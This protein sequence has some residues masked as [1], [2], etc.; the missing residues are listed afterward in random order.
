[1]AT[2]V[3]PRPDVLQVPRR[4]HR[5]RALL[6]LG[7]AL[8]SV[9]LWGTRIRNLVAGADDFSAAFIG[10]HA[11]LYGVSLAIA[12]VLAVVGV[13]MWRESREDREGRASQGDRE[14]AE[15]PEARGAREAARP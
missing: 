11:V 1:M 10:V 3:S 9:W 8:W 2:D 14:D 12:A 5:R 7:V 13:R 15:E 4:R 6:L